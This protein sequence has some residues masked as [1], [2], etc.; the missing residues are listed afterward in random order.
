MKATKNKQNIFETLNHLEH[1]CQEA[2]Q[3]NHSLQKYE[4][5]E[6]AKF[7]YSVNC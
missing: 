3:S 5:G 2:L 7:S 4:E 6:M 1:C